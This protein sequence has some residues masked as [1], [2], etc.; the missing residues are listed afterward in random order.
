[1]WSKHVNFLK[2]LDIP[3]QRPHASF[4]MAILPPNDEVR[5]EVEGG[6]WQLTDPRP[7]SAGIDTYRN[8][9]AGSRGEFTVAKDIYVRTRSGWFSDRAVCYLASGRPVVTMET[10]LD[11]LYPAGE[12]LL[13]FAAHDGALA[14]IDA[15]AG[16]YRRHS[17]AARDLAREYF[18]GQRVVGALLAEVGL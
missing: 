14:A 15:I 18:D 11:R 16:D 10:G 5:R 9:I 12:G 2:F 13:R 1:L 6:G 17:R 8:F 3:R 4:R 7:I